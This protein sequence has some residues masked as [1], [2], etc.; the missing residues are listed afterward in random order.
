MIII[1]HYDDDGQVY[2]TLYAHMT[3][4][5]RQVYGGDTVTAGQAIRYSRF[6]W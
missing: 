6:N 3:A 5:S 1:E 4:G 2:Y